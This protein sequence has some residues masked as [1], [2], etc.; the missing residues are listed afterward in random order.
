MSILNSAPKDDSVVLPAKNSV[1]KSSALNLD[2]RGNL[3]VSLEVDNASSGSVKILDSAGTNLLSV[4]ASGQLTVIFPSAQP[5][6][7]SGT[8]NIGTVT[9]L[10]GITN[11]LPA[12]TNNIGDVDVLTLPSLIA[13]SA[14]IGG[15]KIIDTGGTNALS[16]DSSNRALVKIA[17]GNAKTLLYAVISAA[18]SGAGNTVVTGVSDK[19]TYVVSYLAISAGTVNITWFSNLTAISGAM[20]LVANSGMSVI[21]TPVSP[22]LATLVNADDL[23]LTLSAAIQVSGHITYYQE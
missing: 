6:T 18:N 5:V 11:A 10:T 16:I 14:L 22:V 7:Q 17:D 1:G 23:K 20:P 21:S 8:W 13:G 3:R 9:T 19:K 12:G 2:N 4:N 15:V